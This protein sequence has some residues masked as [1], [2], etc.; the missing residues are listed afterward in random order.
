MGKIKFNYLYR[1]GANFKSWDEVIFKNPEHLTLEEIESR[2]IDAFLPDKLFVA[3]QISIPEKFLFVNGK[4]TKFDHCYHEFDSVEIC[5]ENPTDGLR[6]S[7]NDFLKIVEQVSKQ[8]WE[9]FDILE[10]T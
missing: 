4:F 2:L 5:Q 3:H 1:D 6:R 8:G 10:H 9:A 7:I